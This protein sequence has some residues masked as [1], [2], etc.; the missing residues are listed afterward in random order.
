VHDTA[1]GPGRKWAPEQPPDAKRFTPDGLS[2]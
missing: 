2:L 1:C